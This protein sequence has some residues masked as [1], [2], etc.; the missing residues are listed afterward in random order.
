VIIKVETLELAIFDSA[1]ITVDGR[2]Q[3]NFVNDGNGVQVLG[4]QQP[5][6]GNAPATLVGLQTAINELLGAMRTHG[7]IAS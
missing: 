3:T 7:L 5:D 2:I 1:G 6:I 4:T